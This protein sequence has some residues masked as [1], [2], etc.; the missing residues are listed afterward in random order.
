MS[1]PL[2]ST[3]D[4]PNYQAIRPEHAEPAIRAQLEANRRRLAE[5]LSQPE[6]TFSTLVEPFEE[7]Q[8]R[9]NRVFAPV[10][11][12]NAVTNSDA[13]RAAYNVCLPLLTEYQSE[14]GQNEALARAYETIKSR[15]AGCLTA[16]QR[17]VL[18]FALREFELA[19]V[20]L[21]A[22]PKDRF[23]AL[24]QELAQL[25][26]RFEEQVLDATQAWSRPV[27]DE[28]L[29]AGLPTHVTERAAAQALA[30]GQ[31][32]W[33]LKLDQPTYV[34]VVTHAV[35]VALRREFYQA[36]TTRASD[37]GHGGGGSTTGRCSH[38][39]FRGGT[40]PPSCSAT[41]TMRSCRSQPRWPPR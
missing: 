31:E 36:W 32:G 28:A 4:L 23:K 34:A 2:L 19:G 27:A 13:L 10:A 30:A 40:R 35:S 21:P 41:A 5:L 33:L 9:L 14:V 3:D 15:E 17:R 20:R 26:S 29:L 18:D 37:Q 22:G 11:H 38:R 12:L 16:A 39:S 24:M 25:Q 7:M 6:P 1:N 8:H